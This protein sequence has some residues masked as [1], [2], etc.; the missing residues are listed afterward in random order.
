[1]TTDTIVAQSTA[2]GESA[3]TVIRLSGPRSLELS[4][5]FITKNKLAPRRAELTWFK[6]SEGIKDRCI[7]TLFPEKSSYTGEVMVEI[8]LHGNPLLTKVILRDIINSGA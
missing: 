3:L 8:S 6:T 1:M 4:M 2:P 7:I 5:G